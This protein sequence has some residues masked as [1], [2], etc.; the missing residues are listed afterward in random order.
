MFKRRVE[1]SGKV[2]ALRLGFTFFYAHI[3]NVII[4]LVVA[5]LVDNLSLINIVAPDSLTPI[6]VTVVCFLFYI[7]YIYLQSWRRGQRD[8]NLVTYG[9]I[10]YDR[11]KPFLA[12]LY[13]QAIGLVL[14]ILVQFPSLGFTWVRYAR[15]Y[16]LNFNWVLITVGESFRPIYFVPVLF[17]LIL[18]PIAYHMGYRGIYLAN[19]LIFNVKK[20]NAGGKGGKSR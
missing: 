12:A 4:M 20:E 17:P 19:K 8:A 2:S 9:H 18:A 6:A 11:K 14:G 7:I 1:D 5:M 10:E 3:S 15:Y 16:Y 13:S